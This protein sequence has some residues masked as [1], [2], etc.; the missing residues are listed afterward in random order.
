MDQ[1]YMGHNYMGHNCICHNY[2][3]HNYKGNSYMGHNYTGQMHLSLDL[4]SP[5]CRRVGVGEHTVYGPY[6]YGLYRSTCDIDV[7]INI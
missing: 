4:K 5:I 1:N 2:I 3:D 6:S 7:C